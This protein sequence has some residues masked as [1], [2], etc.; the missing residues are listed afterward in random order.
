MN[1][2]TFLLGS[3]GALAAVAGGGAW[4]VHQPKFGKSPSGRRLERIKAS[5]H[6][7]NGRFQCLEPV[8]TVADKEENY[9]LGKVKFFLQDKSALFPQEPM[10]SHKTNLKKL[11]LRPYEWLTPRIGELVRIGDSGQHFAPWW[12]QIM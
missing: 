10:P 2:R 7:V 1:R 8:E 4:F 5:P 11:P 9:V 6:Y 12:E 3:L